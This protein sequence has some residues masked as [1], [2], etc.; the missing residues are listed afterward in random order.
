MRSTVALAALLA[1]TVL[2]A[3]SW[4]VTAQINPFKHSDFELTEK[5]V[6][7]LKAAAANLYEGE[8][9]PLGIQEAWSNPMSGNAG[10]VE[11]VRIFEHKGLTCRRLQ[12]DIAEPF[13]FI[14]DRRQ[15]SPGVWKTL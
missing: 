10:T 3:T 1:V 8:T 12:H 15:V 6:A 11:L 2:V 9:A 5:D 4:P 13:R 14:I 7:L